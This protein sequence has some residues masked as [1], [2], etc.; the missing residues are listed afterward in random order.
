MDKVEKCFCPFAPGGARLASP[1]VSNVCLP[2]ASL[3]LLHARCFSP[4]QTGSGFHSLSFLM[5]MSNFLST[6]HIWSF[7]FEVF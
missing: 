4:P 1:G 3:H 7:S 2:H 5:N 6:A